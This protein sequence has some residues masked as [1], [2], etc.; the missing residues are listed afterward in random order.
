ME[1]KISLWEIPNWTNWKRGDVRVFHEKERWINVN[2][3]SLTIDLVQG[4]NSVF[5][6]Q[7]ILI[8][9]AIF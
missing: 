9:F 3:A 5:F 6:R 4:Q 8:F 7:Y 2:I 1:P